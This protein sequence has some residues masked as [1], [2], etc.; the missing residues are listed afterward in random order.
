MSTY[1]L[2]QCFCC[3]VLCYMQSS[4]HSINITNYSEID[5]PGPV[6]P[7]GHADSCVAAYRRLAGMACEDV[8]SLDSRI[9][10]Q[11]CSPED[12]RAHGTIAFYYNSSSEGQQVYRVRITGPEILLPDILYCG[13]KAAYAEYT[14][15]TPGPYHAEILHLYENFSYTQQHPAL[16]LQILV[17]EHDFLVPVAQR[18]MAGYPRSGPALLAKGRWLVSPEHHQA[19]HHTCVTR[20]TT[21]TC[22]EAVLTLSHRPNDTA[23]R[24]QPIFSP[25]LAREQDIDTRSCFAN[26][27]VC[28]S[29]DSNV[30]HLYNGFVTLSEGQGQAHEY[31]QAF[32]LDREALQSAFSSYQLDGWLDSE[33]MAANCSVLFVNVGQVRLS[34]GLLCT[35]FAPASG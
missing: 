16:K 14:A 32:R 1:A 7:G 17:G 21:N 13:N 5:F 10:L 33:V 35:N 15:F 6:P 11:H 26:K 30:R 9:L 34:R 18:K 19:F 2:L 22:S 3:L 27:R 8:E 25:R 20:N 31:W 23:L 28:F 24:W 4:G 12:G 29:G